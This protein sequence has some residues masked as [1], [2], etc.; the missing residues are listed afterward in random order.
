M[1]NRIQELRREQNLTQDALSEQIGVSQETIRA[2]EAGIQDPPPEILVKLA[3]KLNAS[4]DYI[5]CQ[6]ASRKADSPSRF[7]NEELRLLD[8]FRQFDPSQ[9]S[10]IL[11]YLKSLTDSDDEA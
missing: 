4:I 2:Y 1:K 6:R 11:D 3:Q 10:L 7:T 8:M 5:F 9:R